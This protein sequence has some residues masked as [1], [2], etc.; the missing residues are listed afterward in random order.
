MA[1][2]ADDRRLGH[3]GVELARDRAGGG[4]GGEQAIGMKDQTGHGQQASKELAGW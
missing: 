4:I 1:M 2:R 3:Q